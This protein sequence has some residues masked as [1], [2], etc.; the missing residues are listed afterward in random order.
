MSTELMTREIR[1]T[2][3]VQVTAGEFAGFLA[4]ALAG[5]LAAPTPVL[6]PAGLAEGAI[7]GTAQWWA[8]RRT[9]PALSGRSWISMTA[10]AAAFAWA[11]ALIA[12]DNA[13]RLNSL[14][15][16][17]LLL[18]ATISGTAVLLSLGTGQWLVLR[19]HVRGGSIW[20]WANA[21]AWAAGLLVFGA[22]TT[23]LWQPGQS[24]VVIALIGALGGLLMA[25]TMAAVTGHFL[26]RLVERS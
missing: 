3:F 5:A 23:P 20:I 6:V 16:P 21:L 1:R 17:A 7:L 10:L 25:A 14:P 18:L 4:P 22:V 8:L 24:T 12:V 11:V 2:W 26:I 15:A 9:F 13:A 19:R